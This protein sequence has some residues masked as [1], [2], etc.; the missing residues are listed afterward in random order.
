MTLIV[1]QN[2]CNSETITNNIGLKESET[3]TFLYNQ[4]VTPFTLDLEGDGL[5]SNSDSAQCPFTGF[6][7]EKVTKSDG[8]LL[9]ASVWN[10]V[11]SINSATGVVTIDNFIG[12]DPQI[13]TSAKVYF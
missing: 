6:Q 8:T 7:I 1:A 3:L 4:A 5:I 9:Q 12:A 11:L 2:P 13:W 10:S